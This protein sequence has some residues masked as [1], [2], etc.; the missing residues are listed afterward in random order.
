MSELIRWV[1]DL[2]FYFNF[3]IKNTLKNRRLQFFVALCMVTLI[4]IGCSSEKIKE[5]KFFGASVGRWHAEPLRYDPDLGRLYAVG[6]VEKGGPSRD[7]S[8]IAHHRAEQKAT[9]LWNSSLTPLK[10]LL[11]EYGANPRLGREVTQNLLDPKK[12][13]KSGKV[14]YSGK[15]SYKRTWTVVRFEIKEHWGNLEDELSERV[16]GRRRLEEGRSKW[17][18]D[19]GLINFLMEIRKALKDGRL[20]WHSLPP[21]TELDVEG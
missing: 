4:H 11:K 16:A 2:M 6:M 7:A 19:T 5:E 17:Q 13:L 8:D 1:N 18:G 21:P 9:R 15:D 12:M 3:R 20:S 14:L 10:M